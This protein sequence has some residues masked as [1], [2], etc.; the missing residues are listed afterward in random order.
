MVFFWLL[1]VKS[2]LS[3]SNEGDGANNRDPQGGDS[4]NGWGQQ[5]R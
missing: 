2:N 3:A 5:A 4:R 1:F